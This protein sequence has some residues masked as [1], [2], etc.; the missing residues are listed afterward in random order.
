MTN[1]ELYH[2]LEQYFPDIIQGYWENFPSTKYSTKYVVDKMKE[3]YEKVV[4]TEFI[5]RR[6]DRLL[7]DRQRYLAY[8]VN[9]ECKHSD[10]FIRGDAI[11][12]LADCVDNFNEEEREIS[13]TET[14]L[15]ISLIHTIIKTAELLLT[16]EV[17]SNV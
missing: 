10:T 3:L 1:K 6:E 15:Y 5:R 4:G 2:A 9:L 8:V 14:I 17:H 16:K 11:H 7:S 12:Q 13:P